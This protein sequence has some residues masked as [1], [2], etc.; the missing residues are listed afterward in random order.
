MKKDIFFE[1]LSNLLFPDDLK[2]IICDE[3][4]PCYTK[5]GVCESCFQTLPFIT[6][7]ICERCG[8]PIDDL[9]N[10][11][12]RCKNKQVKFFTKARAVF[13][14]ENQIV[15][16][17]HTLKFKQGRYLARYLSEFLIELFKKQDWQIDYVV[18][19]P[20]SKKRLK[21]RGYNQTELITKPFCQKL[22]L[23]LNTTNLIKQK[24]TLP[25]TELVGA[26]RYENLIGAFTV[27]DKNLFKDKNILV[28]DDIMTTGSTMEEISRILIKNGAKNVYALTVAHTK[29]PKDLE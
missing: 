2:C 19:V 27:T 3:E 22:N 25:Q 1:R 7:N 24:H 15:A 6:E 4:L 10:F 21:Q 28:I 14:Y 18:P 29:P 20:T 13:S 12:N 17:L 11:C 16:L 26:D 5:F 8:E 23:P 9:S